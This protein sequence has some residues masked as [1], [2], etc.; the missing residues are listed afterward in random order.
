MHK[1]VMLRKLKRNNRQIT[2]SKVT[3]SLTLVWLETSPWLS[4]S[5][6]FALKLLL[7]ITQL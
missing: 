7:G 3:I 2:K 6:P 5:I 4:K 1:A